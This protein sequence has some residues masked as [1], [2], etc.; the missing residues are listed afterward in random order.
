MSISVYMGVNMI[1]E[2]ITTKNS[3]NAKFKSFFVF[4]ALFAAF[5]V[6]ITIC[7]YDA[8]FMKC[9]TE[10]KSLFYSYSIYAWFMKFNI[11]YI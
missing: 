6:I 1:T 3:K 10:L 4:F 8:E 9:S 2:N 7:L 5:V 11:P